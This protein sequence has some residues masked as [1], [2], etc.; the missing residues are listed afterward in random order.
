MLNPANP[1][2]AG[3]EFLHLT[4]V[5]ALTVRSYWP[6]LGWLPG[7]E[8]GEPDVAPETGPADSDG[9]LVALVDSY[10]D[11]LPEAVELTLEL[12]GL[13][14]VRLVETLR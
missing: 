10:S 5:R 11:T 7:V 6:Q 9:P 3:P 1:G 8:S 2:A 4:G 12:E 13:G 14:Q